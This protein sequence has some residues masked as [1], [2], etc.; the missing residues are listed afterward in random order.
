MAQLHDLQMFQIMSS[1]SRR[2]RTIW[3]NTSSSHLKC[4][5]APSC[6]ASWL[7]SFSLFVRVYLWIMQTS[8]FCSAMLL[9][10][11]CEKR[12]AT[13]M[14]ATARHESPIPNT[15]E[16][17]SMITLHACEVIFKGFE[18]NNFFDDP[19]IDITLA[20]NPTCAIWFASN[21]HFHDIAEYNCW[22]SYVFT[23]WCSFSF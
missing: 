16:H 3:I 18:N 10:L 2:R 20:H 22:P 1:E 11:S 4:S 19:F 17:G 12:H 21:L 6:L 23:P 5:K 15:D 7:S 14:N 13:R 8:S 9:I